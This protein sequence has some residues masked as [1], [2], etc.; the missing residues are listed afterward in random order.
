MRHDAALSRAPLRT[1]CRR[2]RANRVSS[3]SRHQHL[4]HSPTPLHVHTAIPVRRH[5]R[6]RND[7]HQRLVGCEPC[8]GDSPL[9]R[10]RRAGVRE[11]G[12]HAG[13]RDGEVAGR[14]DEELGGGSEEG[15]VSSN[16]STTRS[17]K[18][19]N[20]LDEGFVGRVAR[21]PETGMELQSGI[22]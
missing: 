5:G 21:E 16:S 20:V 12:E 8:V 18:F 17:V 1:R 4:R 7:I 6:T 15:R 3:S 2:T 19:S 22:A 13:F 14:G 11:E 9:W 10:G